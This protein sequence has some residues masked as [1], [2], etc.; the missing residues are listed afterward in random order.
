MDRRELPTPLGF[1]NFAQSYRAAAE[2]LRVCK[3]RATHP[4]APVLFNYY[5]SIELYLKAFLRSHGLSAASL[6]DIS[7]DFKKLERMCLDRGLYLDDEVKDVLAIMAAP[8]AWSGTRYLEVGFGR[9]PRIS[10]LS[11]VCRKIDR[12]VGAALAEKGL[13]IRRMRSGVRVS[14]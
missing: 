12:T 7:H 10:V 11:R 1:F 8:G 6:Q 5:H 3:L 14:D 13:H 4:H 9:R 2:K